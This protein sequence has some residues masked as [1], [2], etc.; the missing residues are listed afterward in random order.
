MDRD[1]AIIERRFNDFEKLHTDLKAELPESIRNINFPKRRFF[2]S[3]FSDKVIE[4]RAQRFQKYLNFIFHQDQVKDT[5]AFKSFFYNRHLHN[6]SCL[7]NSWD[8]EAS[9][10]EFILAYNLQK[11]LEDDISEIIPTLCGL[12]EVHK[13]L[14]NY[15]KVDH[16]GLECLT[17]LDK[18]LSNPFLLPLIRLLKELRQNLRLDGESLQLKYRKYKELLGIDDNQPIQTLREVISKRF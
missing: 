1:R 7:L 16:Y 12:V 4:E 2:I 9:C 10:K 8:Y 17:M 11:K 6:A 13:N 5:V 3:N 15:E 18:N 14:Q